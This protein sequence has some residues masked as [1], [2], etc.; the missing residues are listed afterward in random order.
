MADVFCWGANVGFQNTFAGVLNVDEQCFA[1][2]GFAAPGDFAVN[3]NNWNNSGQTDPNPPNP[4]NP[5]LT[6]NKKSPTAQLSGLVPHHGQ[7]N[8]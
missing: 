1:V 2:S 6:P 4:P 3:R 5:P 8:N 7:L